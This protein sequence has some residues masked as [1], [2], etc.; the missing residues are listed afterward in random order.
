[1]AR[2]AG[3]PAALGAELHVVL[4]APPPAWLAPDARHALE[5]ALRRLQR[6]ARAV[7]RTAGESATTPGSVRPLQAAALGVARTTLDRW[8]ADGGWLAA[9]APE[10][11]RGR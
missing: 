6:D 2:P 5:V 4:S 1:M 3:S 10:A 11:C 8:L 9:P 7:M